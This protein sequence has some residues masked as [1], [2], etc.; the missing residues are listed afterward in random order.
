MMNSCKIPVL[1]NWFN[2]Y[3][4]NT[5]SVEAQPTFMN[6]LGWSTGWRLNDCQK[7]GEVLIA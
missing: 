7:D 6:V 3:G 1:S 2:D 5:V 4:E